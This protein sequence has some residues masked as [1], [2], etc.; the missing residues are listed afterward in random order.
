MATQPTSKLGQPASRLGFPAVPDQRTF[1]LRSL[2][3]TISNIR[4]RL[5]VL[6]Q[7][8]SGLSNQTNAQAL[9]TSITQAQQQLISLT[10][11]VTAIEGQLG[12]ADT[13]TLTA[14]E[15]MPAG[16]PVVPDGTS[17][18]KL[19]NPADA[20]SV[21]AA[22]GLT[23]QAVVAGQTVTVQR[24]GPM[25]ISGAAFEP[26]KAVYGSIGGELTQAPTVYGSVS[27]QIGVAT[28]A[29][30]IWVSSGAP[31]ALLNLGFD[32]DFEQFMP[33]SVL[34]VSDALTLTS[35]VDAAAV[36][37]L[38]KIADDSVTSRVL[39]G[40]T[41]RIAVANGD[42][43]A[44][45]PTVDI[46]AS[47]VGQSSITT[48]GTIG[49]GIWQGSAVGLA[50]G[51]TGQVTANS[52]LNA[53][54]PTQAGNS[55]KFLTTNGSDTSWAPVTT[56]TVTSV[57]VAG[58]NG[59]GV[60]GSPITSSGT[61]TLS[62]GA[63]TPTS[64]AASGAVTG[65]NLSGTNTG[66]QTIT[67]TG[68]VTGSGTGSFATTLATVNS[69]VGSFGSSTAI[70]TLTVNGKGLVTAVST[71]AVV[72]PAGTLT[73]TTLASNVVTSSL[74]SVGTIGTGVWQGTAVTAGFGGTGQTSYAVG[75]LLYASGSTTLSK[76]A[77]VA[78]GNALISGGVTT[79][80]SWGKIGLT[81]HVSGTLPVANGGTGITSL[82]TGV[83]TWLGTPS[84]ANLAAA[85]TDETG[86]GALVFANTPTLVTPVIGAAT[87]TSVAL[88][89]G[90]AGA[91]SHTFS[92]DTDTGMYRVGTNTLG[93]A[94]GGSL[95]A[96]VDSSG[97]IGAGEAPPAWAAGVALNLAANGGF[98]HAE[99]DIIRLGQ[100]AYYNG[101][102]WTRRA[103]NATSLY[104]QVAGE[105]RWYN[106]ASGSAGGTFTQT[107]TMRISP[108]VLT[109]QT[110]LLQGIDGTA[111]AP[112]VSFSG[113]T[114]TGMYRVGSN[115][116][117]LAT[118]GALQAQ[119]DSNGFG[120][121]A[122]PS[123]AS[124]TGLLHVASGTIARME[125]R[126]S[127][128]GTTTTDGAGLVLVGTQ[129][130]L[131]NRENDSIL[132]V[133]NGA[134]VTTYSAAGDWTMPGS[135]TTASPGSGAG[136][137]KLGTSIAGVGLALNTTSY[138]EI[139]IGGAVHKLAKVL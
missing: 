53:L 6:D 42:G 79:A 77:D 76:L 13:I 58:N 65:S 47:Y 85:V 54:L 43:V 97:N 64:V 108:S 36:G 9:A 67:L 21:F 107:E 73:G 25:T 49:T 51:G 106:N 128:S 60:S 95:R 55:G 35:Q 63:I 10:Q 127:S 38:T 111:S 56:G 40:T 34:L 15:N 138:V 98:L 52:A 17:S 102:N 130:Q 136:A 113:D 69:N 75:D 103:A 61:I 80:P 26:G 100:N 11:R 89:D 41:N 82:G 132:F 22:I 70:P 20:T 7:T 88:G 31:P 90:S 39:Q 84:S 32:L 50:Y 62:L 1:D 29:S 123:F 46:S 135:L 121:G 129:L 18:C 74:T 125:L 116:I 12:V 81:T 122:A 86:T 44:G 68:D 99:A 8:V 2:N 110:L 94:T 23:T 37:L 114:D 117:G 119:V 137:W 30:S 57:G 93:F 115:A 16:A 120:S 5:R 3:G 87:G 101:T 112:S 45:N 48:L 133:S 78:T 27:G 59:I 71:N 24:R 92:S 96:Q 33:A 104:L 91:P 105:H 28:G 118:G 19:F 124:G 14:S 66:D 72:A 126:N 134:N 109:L 131:F 4:E 139:S 83:A